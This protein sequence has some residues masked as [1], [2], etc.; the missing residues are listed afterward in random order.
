LYRYLSQGGRLVRIA[1]YPGSF[2][3][4]TNGHLDIA[5]RASKLFDKLI[6]GVYDRPSEK[7]P[8]FSTSER[9]QLARDSVARIPNI[10]VLPYKGLTG[11]FARE[12]KAGVMVRGLR[13]GGDFEYEF[14]LASMSK[15]LFP[16]LEFICL[17][18]SSE[19]QFLSSTMLKEAA[20]LGG[21][22][23]A[24]VPANVVSALLKKFGAKN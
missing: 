5:V 23:E 15:K 14:N 9:V 21:E 16:E 3:P 7:T 19:Y 17:M 24:L 6:I 2:D 12:I 11:F 20:S 10:E 1:I 13:M 8:L 4:I 18:A 22:I